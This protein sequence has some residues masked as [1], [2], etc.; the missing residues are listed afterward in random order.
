MLCRGSIERDFSDE[1]FD[2][3]WHSLDT[4]HFG[5]AQS[6]PIGVIIGVRKGFQKPILPALA[7]GR[8]RFLPEMIGDL[9]AHEAARIF[10]PAVA[11]ERYSEWRTL[12]AGQVAPPFFKGEKDERNSEQWAKLG[13]GFESDP[14]TKADELFPLTI[15]MI[16][17]IQ[18]HPRGWILQG[19]PLDQELNGTAS[20][21]PVVVECPPFRRT[22]RLG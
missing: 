1:G 12:C 6:R 14:R 4:A 10:G 20:M 11:D 5:I 18:G 15:K 16:Q 7:D 3:K 22:C 8:R 21:P 9:V 13:L 2:V 19:A 17:R